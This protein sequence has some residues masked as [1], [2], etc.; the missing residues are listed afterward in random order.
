MHNER[1]FASQNTLRHSSEGLAEFQVPNLDPTDFV[2]C[3]L[4]S[5]AL[6]DAGVDLS[7]MSGAEAAFL[8]T[9]AKLRKYFV[10][11]YPSRPDTATLGTDWTEDPQVSPAASQIDVAKVKCDPKIYPYF[12]ALLKL[13][14]VYDKLEVLQTQASEY[15]KICL[16]LYSRLTYNW[17]HAKNRA[18]L[19]NTF[20]ECLEDLFEI[21]EAYFKICRKYGVPVF[22]EPYTFLSDEF[23]REVKLTG[24]MFRRTSAYSDFEIHLSILEGLI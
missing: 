4:F 22:E 13:L 7:L 20:L 21:V 8:I 2:L 16:R 11:Q 23:R 14:L 1:I 15:E 10:E 5:P 17:T 9:Y 24:D 18:E 3:P 12:E 19:Q 6:D